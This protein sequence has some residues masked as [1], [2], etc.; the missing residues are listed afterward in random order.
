MIR[1][2]SEKNDA[3]RS[4]DVSDRAYFRVH[5]EQTGTDLFFGHPKRSRRNRE[6]F[7]PISV[8]ITGPGGSFAGVAVASVDPLYFMNVFRS[9][10]IGPVEAANI[11]YNDGTLMA[12]YP[13]DK[14]RIGRSFAGMGVFQGQVQQT[15]H[16]IYVGRSPMDGR[17]RIAAYRTIHPYPL[18]VVM[19]VRYEQALKSFYRNLWF[20]IAITFLAAVGV[21]SATIYQIRQTRRLSRY[22]ALLEDVVNDLHESREKLVRQEKLAVLG[23]LAGG[24]GHELRNPLGVISN[25]VYFLE[26]TH[27]ETDDTTKEYFGIIRRETGKAEKIIGDLLDYARVKSLNREAVEVSRLLRDTLAKNPLP[28]SIRVHMETDP[29]LPPIYVDPLKIEQVLLNLITN[30]RQAMPNEGEL[31]IKAQSG[32]GLVTLEITDN[33]EGIVEAELPKI[34]EPLFTTKAKGIGLGLAV[35]KNLVESNGGQIQVVSRRGEGTTFIVSLPAFI[36]EGKE[37]AQ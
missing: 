14:N 23:Q 27:S 12:R 20:W 4:I 35:S 33:G 22:S 18:V 36:G 6:W 7:I 9:L 25:A 3:W 30:A 37:T 16:G 8:E 17:K 34:F 31:T 15:D 24:V 29:K 32:N 1:N 26:M 5:A 2:D 13:Q 21:T 19:C 10:A 11:F 28:D